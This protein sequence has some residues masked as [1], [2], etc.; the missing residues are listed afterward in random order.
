MWGLYVISWVTV[1]RRLG[2]GC[3]FLVLF[4]RTSI[5]RSGRASHFAAV[6]PSDSFAVTGA[7]DEN[8]LWGQ[9][10]SGGGSIGG[11][12]GRIVGTMEFVDGTGRRKCRRGRGVGLAE[13]LSTFRRGIFGG[14]LERDNWGENA[15][16]NEAKGGSETGR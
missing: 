4:A 5:S 2:L 6:F 7:H 12:G 16:E 10:L 14:P 1:Y 13:A 3:R 11:L 9:G 8:G 15:G